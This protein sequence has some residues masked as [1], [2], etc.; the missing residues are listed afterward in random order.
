LRAVLP[1]A[2]AQT[3]RRARCDK[4]PT[5]IK[6]DGVNLTYE[7]LIPKIQ[8]SMLS[9]DVDQAVMVHVDWIIDLGPGAGHDGG[10]IVFEGTP[11][12]DPLSRPRCAG[13]RTAASRTPSSVPASPAG[14]WTTS[15][16]RRPR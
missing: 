10:R 8:K 12:D 5:R 14:R 9:K 7:G 15:P 3:A 2:S 13:S 6:V 16:L 1:A 11:S 4:E